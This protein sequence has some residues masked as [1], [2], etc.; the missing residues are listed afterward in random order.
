MKCYL[1]VY[2]LAELSKQ[3]NVSTFEGKILQIWKLF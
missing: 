1:L 2:V 3:K